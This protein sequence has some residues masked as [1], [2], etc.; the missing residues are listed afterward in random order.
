MKV[1]IMAERV[2]FRWYLSYPFLM[3]LWLLSSGC[4]VKGRPLPPEYPPYIGRG[5]VEESSKENSNTLPTPESPTEI[6]PKKSELP[7]QTIAPPS[8]SKEA[9]AKSKKKSPSKKSKEK[10]R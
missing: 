1:M 5:M 7:E 10:K 2:F 8:E 4:G 9:A 6:E 3:S